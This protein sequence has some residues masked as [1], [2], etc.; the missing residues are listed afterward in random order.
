M[1]KNLGDQ[2]SDAPAVKER[3]TEAELETIFIAP[4][5][6][7]TKQRDRVPFK[8]AVL[9]SFH[10]PGDCGLLLFSSE[11]AHVFYLYRNG[12]IGMDELQWF[13]ETC[14][15]KRGA[16]HGMAAGHVIHSHSQ[17]RQIRAATKM[18]SGDIDEV[19]GAVLAV[20][21]HS[22]LKA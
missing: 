22:R 11:M 14:Q 5:N 4:V 10:P 6:M 8:A 9:F 19:I 3:L 12:R 7:N 20:K 21:N 13:A 15:I 18:K 1:L 16:Q 2:R 17:G